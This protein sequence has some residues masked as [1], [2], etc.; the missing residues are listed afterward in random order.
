LDNDFEKIRRNGCTIYINK[1]FRNSTFEQ[2]LTAGEKELQEHHDLTTIPSSESAH[3]YKFSLRFDGINREIYFKQYL[4]RSVLR[5]IKYFFRGSRAKRE[6]EAALVLAE[7]G[8]DVPAVVAMGECRN[9]FFHR[10]SFLATFGVENSKAIYQFVPENSGIMDKEQLQGW[11]D[12]IRAFGRTVGRMHAKGI[13]HGDLRLGNV[14]ARREGNRWRF[15]FIDN[16]RTKKFRKLPARLQLKNLVQVN[17]LPSDMLANT[18]RMR[19]FREY[20]AETKTSKKQSKVLAE[21]VVE[22]TNWRLNKERLIRRTLRK[23]LRTN[24]RYLRVRTDRYQA[25]FDRNFCEGAEPIDF[26]EQIDVL[27]DKGQIL[28]NGDTTYVSRLTWNGK[29]VVVKRYNHKGLIH[30]LRHT[31]KGSRARRCWLHAHRLRMLNIPTPKPIAFIE[32]LKGYL[33]R[34]SYLVTEYV[35]GQKLYYFLRNGSVAQ[36]QHSAVTQQ[37]MDLLNKLGQ[38]RITH[39]DLKHTNILITNDGPVLTDLDGMRVH[40]W[41]WTCNLRQAKDLA[42]F[43]KNVS[44]VVVTDKMGT[45]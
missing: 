9:V 1:K 29:D 7:N 38:Y 25:A 35:D 16:E 20:C 13:F 10:R 6:F 19:F 41:N 34:Q 43:E 14:L 30:S 3:V 37:I 40:K 15:F 5:F 32:Q 18:D 28:K 36:Q 42:R 23:C 24:D 31:I 4:C 12:L 26:V 33:L 11:R 39:G 21:K 8:F 2:V 27:M 44:S 45:N 17:M 22:K